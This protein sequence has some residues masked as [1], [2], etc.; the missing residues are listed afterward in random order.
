MLDNRNI[1]VT[2]APPI[3]LEDKNRVREASDPD[4]DRPLPVGK[5]DVPFTPVDFQGIH[6]VFF[7]AAEYRPSDL[8]RALARHPLFQRETPGMALVRMASDEELRIRVWKPSGRELPAY[9]FGAGAA[10][11]AAILHEFCD[12]QVLVHCRGGDFFINW[13]LKEFII[14]GAVE[15]VYTGVYYW[16]TWEVEM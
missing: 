5:R 1:A 12:R 16:D 11:A 4:I 14:A 2:L 15:Y 13:G 6:A 10:A 3:L 9:G 7:S 8:R